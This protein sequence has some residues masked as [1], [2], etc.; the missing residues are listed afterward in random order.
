MSRKS[1]TISQKPSVDPK[2]EQWIGG[3]NENT[4]AAPAAA[5]IQPAGQPASQLA[6]VE[7]TKMLSVRIPAELHQKLRVHAVSQSLQIQD[8]VVSLLQGYLMEQEGSR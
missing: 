6:S 5:V 1:S 2:L 7:A 8:I 3:A 4:S